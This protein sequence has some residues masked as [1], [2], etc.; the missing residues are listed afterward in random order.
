M[1]L[2]AKIWSMALIF[3]TGSVGCS[4]EKGPAPEDGTTAAVQLGLSTD[5]WHTRTFTND[6]ATHSVDRIL[7]MPF[8]KT[9][10]DD[11]DASFTPVTSQ[12]VQ[13]D[14]PDFDYNLSLKLLKGS[15][16]KILVLGY[17]SADYDHNDPSSASNKFLL[18]YTAPTLEDFAV[19]LV[20]A[21]SV[22]E[23]IAS[24]E[25]FKGF[26]KTSGGAESFVAS[27]ETR[28]ECT[29]RRIVGGFSI[30]LDDLPPDTIAVIFAGSG[31]SSG[32]MLGGDSSPIPSINATEEL[33][34][35]IPSEGSSTVSFDGYLFPCA[36][37]TFQIQ[38]IVGSFQLPVFDVS[39]TDPETDETFDTFPI[40][41]NRAYNVSGSYNDFKFV[42]DVGAGLDLD[43]DE[44]DGYH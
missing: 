36:A 44:W 31:L 19:T 27:D 15:T 32:V 18:N 25:I 3:L 42:I 2:S 8:T 11:T 28:L 14:V 7:V 9:G 5:S 13:Y 39:A 43:D 22:S 12:M 23:P 1:K 35:M 4:V 21:A 17:N 38:A 24:C 37:A 30:T 20:P 33:A 6:P 16:Y 40:T 34:L 29:L 41:A 10:P 26:A